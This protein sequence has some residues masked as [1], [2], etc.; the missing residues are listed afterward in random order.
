[1]AIIG[2]HLS[3]AGGLHKA[4]E[5]AVRLHCE[6]VQ[7]FTKNAS[8]WNAKPLT[9]EEIQRFREAVKQAKLKF[10]TAHDAYLIN[11][12]APGDELFDKSVA[13]LTIELERA[14]ALG[15]SY[16][17]THPGAHVGSGEEAGLQRVV[18]GLDEVH[19]R[20]TGFKS[21]IL[22]ETTAGQGSTLG[23]RFE[24]IAELLKKVK[25]PER[26]GVC[27]DTCHIFA[28]GYDLRSDD[29]YS[30]TFQELEQVIGFKKI[31]LFHVNDSVKDLGS[32]V[33]RHA[34]IGLGKIGE[35]AFRRLM[36]D[37]RFAKVPKI[38]E[39]PKEDDS[40]KPMDPINLGLLR[41]FLPRPTEKSVRSSR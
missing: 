31:K 39:T 7:I 11:L 21:Q 4:V 30:A 8:Q 24:H 18:S 37:S 36:T 9:E 12:A 26:L 17:V 22:L 28:A 19:R 16:L 35:A 15:L 6:T 20:C 33:D 27:V 5:E 34:G 2:A 32:R 38:L 41:N 29:A 40:G 1:M 3:V 13:A 10:V 25:Q 14:E 23:H